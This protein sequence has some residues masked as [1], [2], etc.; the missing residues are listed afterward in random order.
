MMGLHVMV[1][2]GLSFFVI[3]EKMFTHRMKT[4]GL[5]GVMRERTFLLQAP[6]VLS[7]FHYLFAARLG[8]FLPVYEF[9]LSLAYFMII[10]FIVNHYIEEYDGFDPFGSINPRSLKVLFGNFNKTRL[11]VFISVFDE[12][13]YEKDEEIKKVS[14]DTDLKRLALIANIFRIYMKDIA[15][16]KE[17]PP[18][19]GMGIRQKSKR[20]LLLKRILENEVSLKKSAPFLKSALKKEGENWRESFALQTLEKIE[21]PKTKVHSAVEEHFN[22]TMED[23]RRII[24]NPNV[25]EAVRSDAKELKQRLEE[26]ETRSSRTQ[27]LENEKAVS[28]LKAIKMYHKID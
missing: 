19:E 26:K 20:E 8:V 27:V 4:I 16:Y 24:E 21:F 1:F 15:I 23:L 12:S 17:L 14:K 6:L 3:K 18:R 28:Q 22:P 9:I 7:I 25:S 5:E 10:F 13:P 11:N 2:I